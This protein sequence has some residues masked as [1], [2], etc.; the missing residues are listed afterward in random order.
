MR[1]FWPLVMIDF[2]VSLLTGFGGNSIDGSTYKIVNPLSFYKK[3]GVLKFNNGSELHF[4]KGNKKDIKRIAKFALNNG[5]LLNTEDSEWKIINNKDQD[6]LVTPMGLNFLTLNFDPLIFA[7]TFLFDIH[8]VDFDL[9]EKIVV[10]AGAFVGDTALYY[11]YYG[12]DVYSFEPDISSFEILK[13]NIGLNPKYS[14]QIHIENL[15]ISNDGEVD[16]PVTDDGSGGSSLYKGEKKFRKVKAASLSTILE[17]NN[18]EHPYLLHLD[19]KGKEFEVINDDAISKFSRVRIEYS[20][21]LTDDKDGL[22]IMINR[23]MECGFKNIRHFKHNNIRYDLTR[24]GTID[25][26]K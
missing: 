10:E 23:L 24:H 4:N 9:K 5:V 25:A 2:G 6:I 1:K 12:A 7:E 19:I 26:R 11:A 20:P 8:F 22:E 13:K 17:T 18:L 16:F 21:Y 3:S 15:A 14:N